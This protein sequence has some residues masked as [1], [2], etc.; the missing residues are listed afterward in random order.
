M[1][2][3]VQG[4]KCGLIYLDLAFKRWL[5][6]QLGEQNYQI[7]NP[8]YNGK[9]SFHATEGEYMRHLM[10]RFDNHK[11]WFTK[12]SR[13]MKLILPLPLNNLTLSDKVTLGE[14]TITK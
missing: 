3:F 14:L 12:D 8:S 13:D 2:I 10:K 11:R 4:D 9:I 1:L 6:N 7:L 5:R